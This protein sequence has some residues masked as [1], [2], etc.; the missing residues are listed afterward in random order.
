[1]ACAP[2]CVA[3]RGKGGDPCFMHRSYAM[4]TDTPTAVATACVPDLASSTFSAT[5]LAAA[6]AA[7]A[8]GLTLPPPA[9]AFSMAVTK[10]NGSRE[11]VDLNKIV[12]AITRCSDD[13]YAIDPMRVATRTIS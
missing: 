3:L 4:T 2:P 6:P 11:P 9:A 10:R 13:L 1:M 8:P 5:S 12:R 7:D